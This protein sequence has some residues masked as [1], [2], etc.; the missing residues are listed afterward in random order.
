MIPPGFTE[1]IHSVLRLESGDPAF[2]NPVNM[3]SAME[4][5]LKYGL[6][7]YIVSTGA[8]ALRETFHRKGIMENGLTVP[9]PYWGCGHQ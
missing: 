1:R 5:A 4:Q 6:T 9:D 3:R 2:D 8:P 7:H